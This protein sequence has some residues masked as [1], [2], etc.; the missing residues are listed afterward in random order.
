MNMQDSDV[1]HLATNNFVAAGGDGYSWFS[2]AQ[3][4]L[5]Y[6]PSLADALADF[7]DDNS[8]EGGSVCAL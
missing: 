8:P 1:F 7:I 3:R 6:G 4:V 2:T 5:T